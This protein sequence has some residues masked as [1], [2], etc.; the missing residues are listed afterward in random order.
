MLLIERDQKH[1][2]V[3]V[4]VEDSDDLWHLYNIV[5][6]G[7]RVCGYTMREIKVSRGTGEERAGR[8]RVYLCISVEELSF[9]TFTDRLRIKGKVV[10]APEELNIQGSYHSFSV[11]VRDRL[12]ILKEEWLSFHNERLAASLSKERPKALIVTLDDQDALIYSM[13]DYDVREALSIKSG[14]TG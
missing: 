10:H 11:G 14:I 9:Q 2:M 6:S 7:D 1:G 4:E 8:R 3:E 5:D 13:R 12:K